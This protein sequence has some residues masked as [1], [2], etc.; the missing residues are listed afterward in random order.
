MTAEYIAFH[1]LERP[2]AVALI[3]DGQPITYAAFDRDLRKLTKAAAELGIRRGGSVAVGADDLYTHWLLLLAFERLG[4]ATVSFNSTEGPDQRELLAGVD[5]IVAE[6]HFQ[7]IATLRHHAITR[8]WR[9]QILAGDDTPD[10]PLP[11]RAP[12]DSVRILRTSGTTGTQKRI[13]HPRSLHDAWVTRWIAM[14]GLSHRT[15]L[16]LAMPL[17]VNGMYACATACLRVGGTVVSA[18]M[19]EAFDIA[20]TIAE[21]GINRIILAPIQIGRVLDVLPPGFVKPASLTLCSFGAA[22]SSALRRRALDRLATE[23]VDMYGSNEAGFIAS[24]S[25]SRDDGISSI[26]PGVRVEIVDDRDRPLPRGEAGRIRVR[27]PD[28]VQGYLDD[29]EATRRMFRDGWFYPGDVGILRGS[30][31]LQILGR[32]D[33]LLNFGGR[34]LPPEALEQAILKAVTVG[35]VGVCS[36]RN[37]D[38]IEE[39]LIALVDVQGDERDL[40]ERMTSALAPFRAGGFRAT[41]LPAIPRNANGK[42]QRDRLRSAILETLRISRPVTL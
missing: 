29:T 18:A 10:H 38:G 9:D 15:R 11:P 36:V 4:I 21:C 1:A 42:I 8:E 6:P 37:A 39:V 31:E 35:D 16:L 34:K 23:V 25:T 40:L 14:T 5:L 24:T 17:S 27:T 13:L 41:K 7:G 2:D 26:W 19:P 22:V 12:S 30:L 33:D 28:M 3:D 32:G 20:R